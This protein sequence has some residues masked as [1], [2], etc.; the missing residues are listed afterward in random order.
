MAIQPSGLVGAA[1]FRDGMKAYFVLEESLSIAASWHGKPCQAVA[2]SRSG[3]LLAAGNGSCITIV[4]ALSLQIVY[5]L[6]EHPG[7]VEGLRFSENDTHLMSYCGAGLCYV[8]S[9]DFDQ[10]DSHIPPDAPK[11]GLHH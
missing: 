2:F 10:Y 7:L 5:V 11:G 8:W 3:N 1:G 6:S 4:D 9:S